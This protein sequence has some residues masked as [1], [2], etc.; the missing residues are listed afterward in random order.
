MEKQLTFSMAVLG[1]LLALGMSGA[2][3]ILG[4]QA[5]KA[6]SAQQSVSVKGLAEKAVQA[7]TAEWTVTVSLTA[8]DF[9]Q[10]L[11]KLRHA[12]PALDT[13]LVEHGLDKSGWQEGDELITPH[14]IEV[15]LPNGGIRS[16]QSGFDANQNIV[17]TTKELAKV[18]A[19]NKAILSLQ[20]EGK[21][22]S[23]T[24]P[25]YLVSNL[26]EIKM[27]LISAATANARSRAKEFVKQDGVKVGVMRSASQGAFYITPPGGT[28]DGDDYGGVYDKTTINKLA[29]VVVTIVYNI[30]Q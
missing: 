5:K 12:R 3:F 26:E 19:A 9:A 2:A 13:F 20:A 4:V 7:D 16:E 22:F 6:V 25:S 18:T 30:E 11:T 8:P 10:A 21:P 14:M 29:K 24:P 27:S 23:A 17:V 28:T 1:L 15:P